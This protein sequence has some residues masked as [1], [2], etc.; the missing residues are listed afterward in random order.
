[1]T[2]YNIALDSNN[3]PYNEGGIGNITLEY[4][5]GAKNYNQWIANLLLPYLGEHNLEFG[6]GIGTLTEIIIKKKNVKIYEL[7]ETNRKILQ[8]KFGNHEKVSGI[9]KNILDCREKNCFDSIYSSNVLE[10]VEKDLEI[11]AHSNNILKKAGFFIAFVPAGKMLY[12]E[13]DRK[14]GHYRRYNGRDKFRIMRYLKEKK[15][16]MK[17][18][19]FRYYNPIGALSWFF[20]MR[21]LGYSSIS[22]FDICMMNFFIKYLSFIDT[23]PMPFGQNILIVIQKVQ[24]R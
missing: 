12:S 1:M 10:H 6:A 21:L 4:L 11:I 5:K 2:D 13:C 15:L 19:S 22:K 14:L 20:K 18:V 17:L 8:K 24:W 23:L 3:S 16:P 9:N 7:S